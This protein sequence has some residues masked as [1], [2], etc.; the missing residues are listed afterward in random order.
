MNADKAVFDLR[1]SAFIC[2][3]SCF[4]IVRVPNLDLDQ[5]LAWLMPD[6]ADCRREAQE[7]RLTDP[8]AT[9]E[10]IARRAIK[11]SRKWAAAIGGATGAVASPVTML[12]AAVADMAAML[13]LEGKLA[14]T[15]AALLD[16]DSLDDADTFRKEILTV[17][18]PGA[19]SQ[20]LR[21]VGIRASEEATKNLVR[22]LV[23][24]EFVKDLSERAAKMLGI[25][26]TEKA[27]ATKAIPL[28][29]A[30]IGAAWNFV[31]IQAVGGRAIGY[32]LGLDSPATRARKKVVSV[33]RDAR[34]KLPR[35]RT[36]E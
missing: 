6:P 35:R 10:Q 11:D 33:V 31:E 15:I 29:G 20:A 17:V 28:V 36:R 3:W 5:I 26:L 32:H 25:R 18:F 8:N 9:S 24:R 22:K 19:I 12:P 21:K 23:S 27:I 14:G 34:R 4:T 1:V 16:P 13:R 7:L 30:G 2:G